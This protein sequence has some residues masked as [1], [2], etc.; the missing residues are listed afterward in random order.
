MSVSNLHVVSRA[1]FEAAASRIAEMHRRMELAK[2]LAGNPRDESGATV[3]LA[4]LRQKPLGVTREMALAL[5]AFQA[6]FSSHMF[7]RIKTGAETLERSEKALHTNVQKQG[8]LGQ[9]FARETTA[10]FWQIAHHNLF[11][12]LGDRSALSP[13]MRMYQNARQWLA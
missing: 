9:K 3:L 2:Q 11:Y 10:I 1:R 6:N 8:L 5:T 12:S 4:N 13:W 7:K